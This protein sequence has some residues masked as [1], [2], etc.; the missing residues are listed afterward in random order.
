MDTNVL[1]ELRKPKCS[2]RV[3]SWITRRSASELFV[4]R[5]TFAEIRFGIQQC[6]D[7]QR[8]HQLNHWLDSELRPWFGERVIEIDEGVL[9]RWREL[10]EMGR[11][12]GHPFSQPDLFIAASAD[13]HGL[14]VATRNT[15]DFEQAGVAVINPWLS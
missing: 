6:P 13:L 5:V 3:K 10:V 11:K 4:S 8:R 7:V 14:C 15:P 1:S 2:A 9:L 12:R